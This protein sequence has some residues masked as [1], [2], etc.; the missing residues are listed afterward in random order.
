MSI[1]EAINGLMIN[2]DYIDIVSNNISNASTIGF[3][4][5]TPSFFDIV[6]NSFY[7]NQTINSGVGISNL[8]QNFS[9][10]VLVQTNRDLDLGIVRDG[11]FRVL[12]SKGHIHYTR[13]GHFYLMEIKILLM[14][15]ECI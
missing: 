9:D 15:K 13:N 5:S 11:F 12:D 14:L 7:S 6:S 8:V 4:S 2:S 3:K 1:M 10:G